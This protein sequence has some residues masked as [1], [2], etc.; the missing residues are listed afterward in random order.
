MA[1]KLCRCF[2]PLVYYIGD[3]KD[4]KTYQMRRGGRGPAGCLFKLLILTFV[5]FSQF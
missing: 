3:G 5:L 1:L 2:K 4:R